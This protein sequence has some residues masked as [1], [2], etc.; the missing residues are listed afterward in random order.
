MSIDGSWTPFEAVMNGN[1]LPPDFIETF[2]LKINGT[3][4]EIYLG[5]S[6]DKGSVKFLPHAIPQ[7]MDLNAEDGPN[8]GKKIPAIFK[9]QGNFLTV[10]YNMNS[11][12]RPHS[13]VS[14]K[15]NNL[16]VVKY[17]KSL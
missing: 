7:A 17:K 1:P 3:A 14:T 2:T 5:N 10:A 8:A 6:V 11:A 12:E 9:L 15:E 16:Y 13:F 4:Y